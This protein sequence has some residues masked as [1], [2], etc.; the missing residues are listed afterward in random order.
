MG[1]G[2]VGTTELSICRQIPLTK[3]DLEPTSLNET[4]MSLVRFNL[5]CTL[6]PNILL[7]MIGPLKLNNLGRNTGTSKRRN[8]FP[9][10]I[11]LCSLGHHIGNFEEVSYGKKRLL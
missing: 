7:Q 10:H 4:V 8:A 5:K 2:V 6:F 1:Y 11:C 9:W 3:R